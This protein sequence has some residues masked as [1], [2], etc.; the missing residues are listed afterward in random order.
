MMASMWTSII[1]YCYIVNIWI[2]HF[3]EL[4]RRPHTSCRLHTQ[5]MCRH[6]RHLK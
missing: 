2:T 5:N 3:I 6:T 1:R 4:D